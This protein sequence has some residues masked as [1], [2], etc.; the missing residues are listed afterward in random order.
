MIV[1]F[2]GLIKILSREYGIP[3][4]KIKEIIEQKSVQYFDSNI[5]YLG[6]NEF[7]IL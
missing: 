1:K 5:K 2:D 7:E 4:N 3:K 6:F